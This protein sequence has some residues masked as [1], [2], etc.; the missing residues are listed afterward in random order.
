MTRLEVIQKLK[1]HFPL[2]TLSPVA[3]DLFLGGS[4][5]HEQGTALY[6]DFFEDQKGSIEFDNAVHLPPVDFRQFLP[7][8][9]Y[10]EL[11]H[12]NLDPEFGE[13]VRLEIYFLDLVAYVNMEYWYENFCERWI[14]FSNIQLEILSHCVLE[15]RDHFMSGDVDRIQQNIENI[16]L[17]K[18]SYA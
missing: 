11:A 12:P 4:I 14:K 15:L 2:S 10:H 16:K 17:Y 3:C 1:Q 9:I 7:I 5:L 6:W 18:E 8:A 13:D